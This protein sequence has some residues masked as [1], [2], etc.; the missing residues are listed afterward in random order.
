MLYLGDLFSLIPSP[1]L[2]GGG[3]GPPAWTDLSNR[4]NR[5]YS[6]PT[7]AATTA[8]EGP[9]DTVVTTIVTTER[10]LQVGAVHPTHATAF[11]SHNPGSFRMPHCRVVSSRRISNG[12]VLLRLK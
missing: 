2:P 4:F 9:G 12:I 10:L 1:P 7:T 8:V 5:Y 6:P 3:D 11:F